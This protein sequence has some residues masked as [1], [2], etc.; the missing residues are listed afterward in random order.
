MTLTALNHLDACPGRMTPLHKQITHQAIN[1][2]NMFKF[3]AIYAAARG[4]TVGGTQKKKT[5]CI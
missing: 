5:G 3:T 2:H 1:M 4:P